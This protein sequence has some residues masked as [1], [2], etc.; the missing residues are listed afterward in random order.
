MHLQVF[1]K[2]NIGHQPIG[3]IVF[4]LFKDVAP[5]ASSFWHIRAACS[6][7]KCKSELFPMQTAENFR[8][9]CTGEAGMGQSG[10][11]L[12][13]K[14]SIFHRVIKEFM[15]QASSLQ[16]YCSSLRTSRAGPIELC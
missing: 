8:Q 13:Y 10:K 3:T 9:L 1:F 16:L 12:H 5:K 11:P 15:L 6:F 4:E 14:G 7:V 2:V